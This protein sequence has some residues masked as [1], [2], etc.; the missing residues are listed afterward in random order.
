MSLVI[1]S[2]Q[3][4]RR[5]DMD[6]WR[7]LERGFQQGLRNSWRRIYVPTRRQHRPKERQCRD[8]RSFAG[9]ELVPLAANDAR[10]NEGQ[11]CEADAIEVVFNFSLDPVVEEVRS[12]I[13]ANG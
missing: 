8:K 6:S 7:G 5:D 2:D 1:C 3:V 11:R 10:A 12:R 4:F 13:G 9:P